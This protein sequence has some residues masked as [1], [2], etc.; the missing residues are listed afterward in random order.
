MP[1]YQLDKKIFCLLIV[2]ASLLLFF[3]GSL[4][5]VLA[6]DEKIALANI[7]TYLNSNQLDLYDPDPG[8]YKIKIMPGQL[9][10]TSGIIRTYTLYLPQQSSGLPHPPFSLLVLIHGFL[11]SG[12]QH[13]NNAEYFAQ[14]GFVV[15][16]PDL[17]KV[18]LGDTKRMH[19]VQDTLDQIAW[20]I[21]QGNTK[22]SPLYGL[23]DSNRI[24]IAGNSAGG[25]VCL[26]MLIEA[27]NAKVPI[28]AVC[29]LDG[30]PWDR[31]KDRMSLIKPVNI[32]SLRA[33]PS[34]CNYH[35]RMLEYLPLLTFP[36]NDVKINGAH[37]CDVENPTTLGCRC[38]CGT[39]AAPFRRIFQRLTY[40][41]FRDTLGAPKLASSANDSFVEAVQDLSNNGLAIANLNQLKPVQ[42]AGKE[43]I[44]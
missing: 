38:V 14:R 37:H 13:S 21:R 6:L 20:L 30:V 32:L 36:Y 3:A 33:E 28:H 34:L 42:L 35:A 15:I 12:R 41:Y 1:K 10:T 26:E 25:A 2:S 27:Q 7:G 18:L 19:N 17:S 24:G 29:S 23:I 16:T 8:L 9:R 44:Q 5:Y 39:S 4:Q 11:M 31:T 22:T 40:L 43:Q